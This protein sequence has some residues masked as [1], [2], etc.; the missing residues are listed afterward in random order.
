MIFEELTSVVRTHMHNEFQ[1]EQSSQHCPP[2][3]P[4]VLTALGES[5]FCA[6][7]EEHLLHGT[8]DTLRQALSPSIFWVERGIR[9]TKKGPVP[10]TLPGHLRAKVFAVTDFNSWYIRGLCKQLMIEGVEVCEVYRA[11]HAYE[12][13]GECALLE[14]KIL[15]VDVVYRGHRARYHPESAANPLAVS[16]PAGPNCH[17]SIRRTARDVNVAA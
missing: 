10:Y 11:E 13:R 9:N 3:R 6:T 14:G 15:R 1:A 16:I 8:E 2:Y 12:P 5:I 17:H 4:K 7:M